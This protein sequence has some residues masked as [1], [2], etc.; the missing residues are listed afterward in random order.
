MHSGHVSAFDVLDGVFDDIPSIPVLVSFATD[1]LPVIPDPELRAEAARRAAAVLRTAR[2]WSLAAECYSIAMEATGGEDLS[3]TFAHAQLLLEMGNLEQAEREARAVV[4]AVSDPA[5]FELKRRAFAL[6]ARILHM[7]G[8]TEAAIAALDTLASLDDPSLVEADT[9]ILQSAIFNA[10][11]ETELAN[12]AIDRL[13]QLEPESVAL[14][15]IGMGQIRQAPTPTMLALGQL[16]AAA[17]AVNDSNAPQVTA[18]Q[19][20]SFTSRSR[21][22]ALIASLSRAGLAAVR[23][24]ATRD[25]RTFEQVTIPVPADGSETADSILLKLRAAGYE[26]ALLV[27]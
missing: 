6:V 11:G 14:E 25:G 27:Y 18:V 19:V 20:A 21:A 2:N 22:E 7:N 23:Q 4:V 17:L 10:A 24:T 3:V 1:H 26:E 5:D 12:R 15:A 13:A 8:D 9:L 16:P